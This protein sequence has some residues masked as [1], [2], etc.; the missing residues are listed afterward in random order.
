MGYSHTPAPLSL[1][2]LYPSHAPLSSFI[3]LTRPHSHQSSSFSFPLI[4]SPP[5][6]L[7][8]SSYTYLSLLSLMSPFLFLSPPLFLPPLPPV[9]LPLLSPSSALFF[10]S[11]TSPLT[12]SPSHT[13]TLTLPASTHTQGRHPLTT[14]PCTRSRGM[15]V[16]EEYNHVLF[17]AHHDSQKTGVY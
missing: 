14:M 8:I 2:P 10:P 11:Q 5:A 12:P 17:D 6:A 1:S 16:C 9:C 15:L 13:P 7:I 4:S 3:P